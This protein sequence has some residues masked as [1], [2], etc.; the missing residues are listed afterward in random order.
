MKSLSKQI[1]SLF[2]LGYKGT[3]PS[4]ALKNL[5]K[6]DLGGVIFFAENILDRNNFKKTV[7]ELKV[8]QPKLITSID[9]EGGRV[10]RTK[11]LPDK[12]EYIPP[13]E[14]IHSSES[15]IAKHYEI[16][17][18]ELVDL[19]INMNFAPVLDIHTNP[20]N[21]VIN[22]R[23]FGTTA[24]DVI[25]Y[26]KIAKNAMR[27]FGI[28]T[29]GKH[30]CGHGEAGLDSHLDLP[31]INLPIEELS[32]HILPFKVAI[33]DGIEGIMVAH[34]HFTA[35]DNDPVP[36]SLSKNVLEYL[37]KNLA[38]KG[39][40]ISDD[41]VMGGVTKVCSSLEA[42]IKAIKAGMDMFIFRDATPEVLQLLQDLEITAQKDDELLQAILRASSKIETFKSKIA[43]K[44]YDFDI[45]VARKD[46]DTIK[47]RLL[48]H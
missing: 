5:I 6:L 15:E 44:D 46:I 37:L 25:K 33:E 8:L 31:K 4:N 19:G 40:V 10:E 13:L 7:K 45:E 34:V 3:E 36:A 29:V 26:S 9:Q 39:L 28:S 12:I 35:F 24:K 42:C 11:N 17:S 30:F 47:N 20:N 38:F 22:N 27:K 43:S 14:I 48:A 18:Q 2:I 23:A 41:M 1:N 32:E 21:P 16:L